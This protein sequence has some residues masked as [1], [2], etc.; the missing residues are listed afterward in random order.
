MN[1]DHIVFVELSF[2]DHMFE[3]LAKSYGD[4]RSR[5]VNVAYFLR[6]SRMCAGKWCFTTS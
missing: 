5:E 2:T 6:S 3:T 4:G 1:F